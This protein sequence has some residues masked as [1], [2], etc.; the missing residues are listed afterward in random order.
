M[1]FTVAES[2]LKYSVEGGYNK[3]YVAKIESLRTEMF[4]E[5]YN[6]IIDVLEKMCDEIIYNY[7]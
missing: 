7:I 3:V 5:E 6:D 2:S 4:Q 1:K